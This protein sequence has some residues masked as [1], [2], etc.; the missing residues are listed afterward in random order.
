MCACELVCAVVI[1]CMC[2]VSARVCAKCVVRCKCRCGVVCIRAHVVRRVVRKIRFNGYHIRTSERGS[3]VILTNVITPAV[4]GGQLS[5]GN[6]TLDAQE[7]RLDLCTGRSSWGMRWDVRSPVPV[8][9]VVPELSGMAEPAR[10]PLEVLAL[11][12]VTASEWES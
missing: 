10:F 11:D 3:K 1:W 8:V 9:F 5:L 4:G 7:M 6:W 12:S 2:V